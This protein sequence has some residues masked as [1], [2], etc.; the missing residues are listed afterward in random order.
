M[1]PI[2]TP[3][4][5]Q[6]VKEV[7][8]YHLRRLDRDY[9]D[10]RKL[11]SEAICQDNQPLKNAM[12]NIGKRVASLIEYNA[13]VA[14]HSK[15]LENAKRNGTPAVKDDSLLDSILANVAEK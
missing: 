12:E 5:I 4:P 3:A 15:S 6:T 7:R 10:L 2:S 1:P 9:L 13:V 14:A 8:E 11:V